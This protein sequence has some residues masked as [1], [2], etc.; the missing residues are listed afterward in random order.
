MSLQREIRRTATL[1]PPAPGFAGPGHT[2]IPVISPQDFAENDPFIAL[3]DD[4]VEDRNGAPV[5]DAHPHAGI[6]TVTLMLEG[7]I[8]DGDAPALDAGDVQWMTAGSGIVHDEDARA[9]GD[10]RLLQL[11]ITLPAA[12]RA[13]EPRFQNVYLRDVPVRREGGTEI[14]LYS[15]ASAGVR[16]PTLNHV[17]VTLADISLAADATAHQDLPAHYN[18]FVYVLEGVVR[19][20]TRGTRISAGEVGWLD[21]RTGDGASELTIAA[22]GGGARLVLYAGEPQGGA[23]IQRGPLVANSLEDLAERFRAYRNGRFPRLSALA[24]ETYG[25]A[26]RE[27]ETG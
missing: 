22:E 9:Y 16:S 19:I 8:K 23:L 3:M 20:G 24:R 6:E 10:I 2:A 14:R 4:R 17:P 18:G 21:R 11:W 1:A 13:A 26:T 15:G 7:T 25:A 12:E 5:G 27:L